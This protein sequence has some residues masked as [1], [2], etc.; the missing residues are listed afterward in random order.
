MKL[1]HVQNKQS[2]SFG[3]AALFNATAGLESNVLLNKA[4]FDITG[5]DIPWVIMAN[6]KEERRER[7]NRGILSVI[8]VFL[9]PLVALPFVNR[10]AMKYVA[11]LTPKLFSKEYNAVKLSNEHLISAE[12]TEIG[13]KELAEKLSEKLPTHEPKIDFKYALEQVKGTNKEKY[14]EIRKRIINAKNFVLGF[15]IL[16][17]SGV[18]GH[19]GFYNDWQTKKKTGQIGYSAELKMADKEI[20]E[21]R[22]KK[23]EKIMMLKYGGFLTALATAGIALPLAVR[24]GLSTNVE[25]KFSKYIKDRGEI[26]DYKD[27]IFMSR[28]P[29]AISFLAA[30]SGVFLASRNESEMKD[31][32]IRSSVA[33]SIFFLGDLLMASVLG[34]LSDKFLKTNII[35]RTPKNKNILH[36]I[37][38][39]AHSLKALENLGNSKTKGIATAI[40]WFNF[41]A[42]SGLAGFVVPSLINKIVKK[43]VSKDVEKA[44][45]HVDGPIFGDS[46]EGRK[47]FEQFKH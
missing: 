10:F 44:N 39:P 40:F 11:K 32:A 12:K 46:G 30:H 9:S 17:V 42:L 43:D 19:I 34:Q 31:N 5:S 47:V 2:Q 25:T 38:P 24:H 29:M 26:F 28:W 14:D 16:M 4:I 6:N 21:K 7:T 20:V 35:N 3:S 41:I 45:S 23:Q 36:N 8:M 27:A 18:F 13:L 22:A 33:L 1:N 15:D 37:L